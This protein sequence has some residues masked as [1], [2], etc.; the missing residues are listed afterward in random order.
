MQGID[1]YTQLKVQ[2]LLKM[3]LICTLVISNEY[4]T[5][6]STHMSP[7]SY[8]S[9]NIFNLPV[10]LL[11]INFL[12]LISLNRQLL[13]PLWRIILYPN[14]KASLYKDLILPYKYFLLSL[15]LGKPALVY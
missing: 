1:N 15:S 12:T 6:T 7:F 10:S 8:V 4:P 13:L 3:I 11:Y 14:T 9:L 5:K 2:G